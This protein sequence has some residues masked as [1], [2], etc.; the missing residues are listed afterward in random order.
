MAGGTHL[1]L[2][3]RER[4]AALKAEG[5]SLRAIARQLGRAASTISRELRR[6]ALPKGGYRPVHA[7]G[8]YLERR[9]R[10]AVLER[11]ERLGRFVRERLL[12]GWT[13]EQIAGWL[14]RGEERGLRPVSLE[15]IYA[16]IHRPGQKGEKLW[17][18]LPRGR[19]RRG[20]RRA[21]PPRSTIAGRRSIHDRPADVQ[22]RKE[23]GHW[24]GDL[25]ICRRTR[26]VLVLKERKTRF[27]L[28]ARLAGKSAAETVAVMMAG[29]RRLRPRPRAAITLRNRTPVAPPRLV[30]SPLAMTT[31][32][33]DAYA[34]WQKGAVENANGRLR[35]DLPRDL[36]LDTLTDAEL[37]EIV[38]SHNLTPRKCLGFLTPLQALLKELGRDV[39]IR[40]A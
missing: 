30:P 21:R 27:V 24:E 6:N 4:L 34:S 22:E 26:P 1:E 29:F 18:L 9:Q 3:E 11:D 8:C 5:L 23:A 20:R 33:C 36:D 25:L 14:Q 31:W 19:A 16:F 13:P 7:E 35:R 37:Q 2:E 28:A 12:E 38:L 17:K 15:T 40:F 10:P 32:I 39:Q